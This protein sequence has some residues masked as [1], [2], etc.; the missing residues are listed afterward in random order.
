M[1]GGGGDLAPSVLPVDDTDAPTLSV[2]GPQS[3][4]SRISVVRVDGTIAGDTPGRECPREVRDWRP[5]AGVTSPA[6]VS[7]GGGSAGSLRVGGTLPSLDVA[8]SFL[9]AVPA[10]GSPPGGAANPAGP[11]GLVVADGPDGPCE[12]LS[13]IFHQNLDPL[14]HSVLDHAG[15]AGRHIA[16]GPVGPFRTLSSSDCHPAVPAGPYVAGAPVGPDDS[17]KVLEP[18]EHSVLDH[19]D[20]AGQHAVVGPVGPFRMLSSS[21]C[22]PAGLADP[23]VAGGPVGP[24]ELLKVLEPLEHSVLDHADPDGQHA[25]VQDVLEPLEHSVLDTAW[26]VDLW[27]GSQFW[28]RKSIRFWI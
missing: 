19:A 24:D 27:R 9:M 15:P 12:T 11:D 2:E 13:P 7:V 28:N 25:V 22:H 5:R 4:P 10:G 1:R 17:F 20:P 14:E 3:V 18:L 23:Y 26:V 21:D 8:G 16:V 6:G